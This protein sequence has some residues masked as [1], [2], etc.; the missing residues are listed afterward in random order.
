MVVA[1]IPLTGLRLRSGLRLRHTVTCRIRR[2]LHIRWRLVGMTGP[3]RQ[4]LPRKTGL[5]RTVRE[6]ELGTASHAAVCPDCALE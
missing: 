6:V 5:K 2:L 4:L 1:L 3:P